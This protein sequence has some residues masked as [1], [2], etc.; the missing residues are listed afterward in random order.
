MGIKHL[1]KFLKEECKDSIKFISLSKLSGKKI[2]V[3]I[4]IYIYKYAGDNTLI[5]NI[6]LMLSVFRNYNIIPVF[7]FDGKPPTEKKELLK[8]RLHDKKEAELEYKKLKAQLE[9]NENMDDQDKQ[10]LINNMD[11]LKKQFVY[12]NKNDIENVKKL[13]S[14]YGATYYDA[15]GEADELCSFLVLKE[16]V[17]ACL[18]E[19]MDM[20]VYGCTRVIRYLSLLNH[21]AVMYDTKEILKNLGITQK[22]MRE[23]CVISGTDYN[24]YGSL[25][26]DR[27]T[28]NLYKTLKYFKKYHKE[29]KDIGFYEWLIQNSSYIDDYDLLIK[30]YNMFEISK[31]ENLNIFENIQIRNGPIIYAYMKEILQ[32]DGFIFPASG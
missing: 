19:D 29:N 31:N 28:P 30:I 32:S 21:T 6:Y 2:A 10:E 16:K 4:S 26:R 25:N 7:I 1:N 3:D 12:I 15:E 14:S 8:K 5:E 9:V 23:I 20:F 24:I 11:I 17:W 27:D 18:S 13:I 22:E